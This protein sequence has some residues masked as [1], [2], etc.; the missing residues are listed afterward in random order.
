M[1]L[2]CLN[3]IH[4]FLGLLLCCAFINL[5]AAEENDTPEKTV[6]KLY[7][8]VTFEKGTTPDWEA[9]KSLFTEK[10]IIVLRTSRTTTQIFNLEEFV[11]DFKKFISD[12][13]AVKTGFTET[14]LKKN[15]VIFGDIACFLVLYEAE[16]PGTDRKNLG[17]DHFSLIKKNGAWK[18]VSITN[19][20]PTAE[21]PIPEILQD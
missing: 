16:I 17:V 18:I 11:N 12:A 10:A 2:K 21:N 8:L 7:E 19:E 3:N 13:N 6:E 1:K 20:V 15:A 9:V 4:L 14:I 5:N